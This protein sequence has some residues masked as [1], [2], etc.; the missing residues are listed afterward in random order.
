MK[1][2]IVISIGLLIVL[3]VSAFSVADEAVQNTSD[4]N[5]QK[6]ALVI[7][8]LN[9]PITLDG[10]SEEEAWK[11]VLPLPVVMQIPNFG[12]PPSEKTEVLIG[13]DDEYVYVAGRLF[14][15]EPEKIQS[16]SKKRD[17][18]EA[19]T[20]WFGIILDTFNDKENGLGFFTTP[21]GLRF[22][23]AVYNDAEPRAPGQ[24]PINLSWNTFW[25]VRTARNGEGW[26]AEMRI[27]F[28]SLRFQDRE[29]QVVMGLI[30]WRYIPRKNEFII[31]P[32]IYPKWGFLSGWKSSQARE[33]RFDGIRSRKPLYIT[34]YGLTGY[35]QN[36]D[37]NDEETAYIH[38]NNPTIEGGLDIKYGLTSNLTLDLTLNTDFAQVEADD[39]QVNLTRFSLYFPEK[40][41]FFQERASIFDFSFG[42]PTKLFYSRA[43]GIYEEEQVRIY[44]GVRLV[45]RLG[46]WDLG[47][48]DMQ[49]APVE[50]LTSEN[51]GVLR[52]RRQVFNPYSYVGGIITTRIG[53]DGSYNVVYGLDSIFRVSSND[54]LLLNWAQCFED[55]R[56]NNPA[57]LDLSRFRVGWERRT[58]EG[59]GLMLNMARRGRDY[60]PGMGFEVLEDYAVIGSRISLGWLPGENSSLQSHAVFGDGYLILRNENNSLQSFEYGPGWTF[61]SRSGYTGEFSVK[62]SQESLWETLEFFDEVDV[63]IGEYT[64]WGFVGT[65]QTPGGRLFSTM[66]NVEGGKFYDGRRLSLTARPIWVVS[67]DISLSGLYQLNRVEFPDRGQEISAHIARIRL[68]ATLSTKFTASAFVQYNSAA[69]AVVANLRFRLNPK[70]GN[71]LYLV[72]N[73]SFNTDRMQKIPHRPYYNNRAAMVKYSYTFNF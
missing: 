40:R 46:P 64:F 4:Q 15:S 59:L 57:S 37:L 60:E 31:F 63:P 50:D 17:Y 42:G 41:L 33:V 62:L 28:S 70:E 9:G 19:N 29:G 73:E 14:D 38:T 26:F 2:P 10:M 68:E 22:D 5:A 58:I 32:D 39:V 30:A 13:F 7:P 27:P 45:G 56:S 34:P 18:M 35:G 20:E 48:L 8:R 6:P 55:G 24:F 67:P 36:N 51:F 21:S 54:Y 71:D 44:G 1:K 11:N 23:A 25:D 16:P 69:G 65:L 49:T 66:L 47:F 43:I 61:S 53:T 72:I 52:M 3:C 12:N